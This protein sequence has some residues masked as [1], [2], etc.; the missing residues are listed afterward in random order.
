MGLH[1]YEPTLFPSLNP[2][3]NQHL[4]FKMK[5]VFFSWLRRASCRLT[6][7]SILPCPSDTTYKASGICQGGNHDLIYACVRMFLKHATDCKGLT[8]NKYRKG[9][10]QVF[11]TQETLNG[12]IVHHKDVCTM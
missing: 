3:L 1:N 7:P 8:F 2:I 4:L 6:T 12:K 5:P 11:L 10:H 9:E